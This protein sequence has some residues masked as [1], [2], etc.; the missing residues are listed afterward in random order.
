M[1][2]RKDYERTAKIIRESNC[3]ESEKQQ[4]AQKFAD[5]FE[6]DNPRFDRQRFYEATKSDS[7]AKTRK[8]F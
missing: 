7:K 2:S 5:E 6:K 1:T 4:S 3:S 8:V